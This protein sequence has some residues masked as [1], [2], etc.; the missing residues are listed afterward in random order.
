M[1]VCD[2]GVGGGGWSYRIVSRSIDTHNLYVHSN[3]MGMLHVSMLLSICC[4]AMVLVYGMCDIMC[5]FVCDIAA[6]DPV[7]GC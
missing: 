1:D 2:G 4:H 3:N 6:G 7:R 5:V